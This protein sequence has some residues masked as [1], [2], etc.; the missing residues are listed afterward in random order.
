MDDTIKQ[1]QFFFWSTLFGSPRGKPTRR[2]STKFKLFSISKDEHLCHTVAPLK[3]GTV[4]KS[5][6][7]YLIFINLLLGDVL[8][9]VLLQDN[10]FFPFYTMF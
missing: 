10:S 8:K 3:G 5:A 9:E 1:V 6:S 2:T 7:L 4:E